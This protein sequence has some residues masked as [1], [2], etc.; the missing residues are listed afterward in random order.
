M[1]R[2]GTGTGAVTGTSG[3]GAF[4]S[5]GYA[6]GPLTQPRTTHHIPEAVRL[7]TST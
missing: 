5:S 4:P 7:P 3:K 2:Y 6:S 1:G